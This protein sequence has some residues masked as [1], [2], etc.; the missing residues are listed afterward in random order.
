MATRKPRKSK[1]MDKELD[2]LFKLAAA[3]GMS[4]A[5]YLRE[6]AKKILAEK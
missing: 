4:P 6:E 2:E 5:E 1:A 3:Q